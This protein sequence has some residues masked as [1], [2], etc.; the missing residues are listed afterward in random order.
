M[1]FNQNKLSRN[2]QAVA[3]VAG[4]EGARLRHVGALSVVEWARKGKA[5]ATAEHA[6]IANRKATWRETAR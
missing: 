1:A 5:E 2:L 6:T 4:G 3:G